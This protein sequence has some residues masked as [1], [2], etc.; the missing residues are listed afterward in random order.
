[1]SEGTAGV[2][3]VRSLFVGLVVLLGLVLPERSAFALEVPALRARVN[4]Y[5]NLLP[6][7]AENRLEE[8]LAAFEQ[9]TGNQFAVLTIESLEGDP[10]EDFS[11]RV[12]ESWKLGEKKQDNGLLLLVVKRDRKVRVETG[13]GLEGTI[14]DVVSSRV[15]RNVIAPAFRSGDY[16]GGIGQALESLMTVASGGKLDLPETAAR[17]QQQKRKRS[18]DPGILL[19]VIFLIPL[20]LPLFSRGR[21]FGRGGGGFYGGYYGGSIGGFGG[22]SFGGGGGGFGGGG[23]GGGGGGGFG[24]GGASG[25]W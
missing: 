7:D 21:R 11:I 10:L 24:G 17:P 22:G 16:A 1:V 25:D 18:F 12:V 19:F 13:Y 8:R 9:K 23:F 3:L 15:I 2:S 14:P 5:A 6:A 4:D 20:L